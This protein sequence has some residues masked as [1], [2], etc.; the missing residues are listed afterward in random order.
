MIA[1]T[2][3]PTVQVSVSLINIQFPGN[4]GLIEDEKVQVCKSEY[5]EKIH[6]TPK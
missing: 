1:R 4:K 6:F 5:P 3:Q 2:P